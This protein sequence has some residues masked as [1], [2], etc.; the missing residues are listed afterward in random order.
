MARY[1]NDGKFAAILLV[2]VAG[3]IFAAN[4]AA[5]APEFVGVLAL[6]EEADVAAKLELTPEQRTKLADLVEQRETKALELALQ[7]KNLAPAERAAKL[8]PYR[9]ES[10]TLGL[11]I[12]TPAQRTR[13]EQLRLQRLGV[14]A[15]GEPTVADR[16]KLTTEQQVKIRD[17]LA[18]RTADLARAQVPAKYALQADYDKQLTGLLAQDQR[19][20]FE[21]LAGS[22]PTGPPRL[23]GGPPSPDG[24]RPFGRGPQADMTGPPKPAEATDPKLAGKETPAEPPKEATKDASKEPA[25][26][27]VPPGPDGKLKFSFRFAPWDEVIK[28]F[29]KQNDLSLVMDSSPQGT[30]NYTDTKEYTPAQ[31]I[32]LL[33]SVLL[34]KGYTLIR[35]ERMLHVVNLEDGIPPNLVPD[36]P[37]DKLDERGEFEL[38][39]VMFPIEKLT[40]EEAE[41]EVQKLLGPQGSVV[42]FPKAFQIRVTETAG[43]LR[44]VRTVLQAIE[45]PGGSARL[46]VFVLQKVT[47]E[48]AM[49]ILRPLLDIPADQFAATDGSVRIAVDPAGTKLLVS[50]KPEQVARVDD[51]L[52]A[53]EGGSTG[54]VDTPQ[55]EVYPLTAADSKSV[56]DV[57]QTLLAGNPE[58]R[59][60]IDPKTGYL[61]AMARPAQHAMIKATIAQMQ[62]KESQLQFAVL[63]L[64]VTDPQTAV[65]AITKLFGGTGSSPS[66]PTSPS[67][68]APMVDA[69]LV[70][71]KLMIRGTESQIAQIKDILTKMGETSLGE[72]AAAGGGN[73]RMLPL[74]G[75]AGRTALEQAVQLW[76]TM[77]K[78][79]IRVVTPSAV[80]PTIRRG[81]TSEPPKSPQKT[82]EGTEPGDAERTSPRVYRQNSAPAPRTPAEPDNSTH[83]QPAGGPR[84]LY[85]VQTQETAP[86]TRETPAAAAPE[87]PAATPEAVAKP[88]VIAK[89][90]TV[91]KTPAVDSKPLPPDPKR[92]VAPATVLPPDPSLAVPASEKAVEKAVEPKSET[93]PQATPLPAAA[94]PAANPT[95]PASPT[96]PSTKAQPRT[97]EPAPIIVSQSAGGL[98]IA[99]EDTAALDEFESLLNSLAS[100]SATGSRYTIFYLKHAKADAAAETLGQILGATSSSSRGGGGGSLM[101]NL[102][103]AALGDMGGG[104]VGSLLGAGGSDGGGT[105]FSGSTQITPDLRLNALIVQAKPADLDNIEQ[106]LQIIDQKEGPEDV[107]VAAKAQMIPCVNTR[108]EDIAE[109]VK[110]VYQDRMV[111]AGGQ[112][113]QPNPADIIR[114]LRGGGGRG[115]RRAED[116]PKMSVGVD[117][118]TNSLV[119]SAP[120]SLFD[121]VKQLVRQLDTAA[122]EADQ[123][124]R[125]VTIRKTNSQSIQSALSA[126][127]GDAVQ[128]RGSTGGGGNYRG[129]RGQGGGDQASQDAAQRRAEFFQRMQ[130]G[131]GFGGPGGGGFGG[132][133]GGGFGGPGGGGFGGR[134]GAFGGG[135]GGRGGGGGGRGGRGGRGG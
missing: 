54:G 19:A 70:T 58:V 66:T 33:N 13:L 69:D 106:L 47:K 130:M 43:R 94:P 126:I 135:G 77:R 90:E 17:L 28:W 121:E 88:E 97:G 108:A 57:L 64:R 32:D 79:N 11:A 7:V 27:D 84:F 98:M 41:K 115:G 40:P 96:A 85:A 56:F 114:A 78:N 12:L 92:V 68:T 63:Q 59:L 14:A 15:L 75:S 48:E 102:A 52:K 107:L 23:M 1:R 38:I 45:N 111:S 118:R 60:T 119:V 100:Q 35:R 110:Q 8:A 42:V 44:A 9:Q 36:V 30:F 117:S 127:G 6:A 71:K 101:G 134:G 21:A 112:Q 24:V 125:V 80:A 4:L 25:I 74:T 95:A 86:A 39:R 132:P 93:A 61:I 62:P 122:T 91:E 99:S 131:G 76:P 49:A 81:E 89:P 51:I 22:A 37:L 65:L 133:G 82:A 46:R 103:G 104:L 109:I 72:G 16:L 87:V 83:S 29:A 10:E 26:P 73:V 105:I 129:S 50:G 20:A 120:E 67:G 116:I 53:I 55:L 3:L 5:A 2:A 128:F 18:K 34:T 124:T 123:T 113:Q 31:A